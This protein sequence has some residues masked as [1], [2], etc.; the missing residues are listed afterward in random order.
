MQVSI[1]D[2]TDKLLQND[3]ETAEKLFAQ[4]Q[5]SDYDRKQKLLDKGTY[6]YFKYRFGHEKDI[7]KY[8]DL[9][10]DVKEFPEIRANI[11]VN[12]AYV[13]QFFGDYD[14]AFGYFGE[15]ASYE[16]NRDKR[17]ELV[18]KA[19]NALKIAKGSNEAYSYI[20][21]ALPEYDSSVSLFLLHKAI[22]DVLKETSP[23]VALLA[24]EKALSFVPND[25]NALFDFAYNCSSNLPKVHYYKRLLSMNDKHPG[26]LNNIGVAYASLGLPASS[27]ESYENAKECGNTLAA[28]NIAFALLEKGFFIQA[29]EMLNWALKQDQPHANVSNALSTLE[30]KVQEESNRK[31]E[32]D[33]NAE[34]RRTFMMRMY[35]AILRGKE[36]DDIGGT[37]SSFEG[38]SLKLD[39]GIKTNEKGSQLTDDAALRTYTI[40]MDMDNE[41]YSGDTELRNNC[42]FPVLFRDPFTFLTFKTRKLFMY[43]ENEK[44]MVHI[45]LEEED[46]KINL[47]KCSRNIAMAK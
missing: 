13:Y 16:S 43:Y 10:A 17:A 32:I 19:A 3:L 39:I 7:Q 18:C 15:A 41:K 8:L 31:A 42:G 28:A 37:W 25:K 14:A 9:L 27:I 6:L 4:L 35:E 5:S 33:K 47:V 34:Q 26:A 12:L 21:Q 20:V 23:D 1:N 38:K 29:R 24:Y 44:Q 36:S 45:L 2:I 40:A 11:V 46:G 22:Y 30:R